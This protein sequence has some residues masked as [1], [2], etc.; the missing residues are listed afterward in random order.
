[1][2]R[3]CLTCNDGRD[4]MGHGDFE[5]IHKP[6][7][8]RIS[9]LSLLAAS[10]WQ[11]RQRM[12]EILDASLPPDLNSWLDNVKSLAGR[13]RVVRGAESDFAGRGVAVL[14]HEELP[15]RTANVRCML[16]QFRA[17]GLAT[18]VIA[19]GGE[20]PAGENAALAALADALV[21]LDGEGGAFSR[22]SAWKAAFEAFPSLRQ[23]CELTLCDD[24]LLASDS[25]SSIYKDMA[26]V[27]CDFWSIS[28]FRGEVARGD[29]PHLNCHHLVLRSGALA[30][31]NFARF[32]GAVGTG[33]SRRAVADMETAFSLWLEAGGVAPG[34][35]RSYELDKKWKKALEEHV[36]LVRVEDIR[37]GAA[38]AKHPG[39]R[40]VLTRQ[41]CP[42]GLLE[43]VSADS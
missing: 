2:G 16:E 11:Q 41:G 33:M 34:C 17:L 13:W 22:F 18:V 23:T 39:W 25:Y 9:L 31:E 43:S 12:W 36:P 37:S 26:G 32:I 21:V 15:G 19:D 3:C 28:M 1:M 20:E 38:D 24:S 14:W 29:V 35:F 27:R 30:H 6:G 10:A 8:K 5:S 42:E 4:V 40:E 7:A